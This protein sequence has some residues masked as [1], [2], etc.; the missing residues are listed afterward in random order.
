[1][2]DKLL[3]LGAAYV[4]FARDRP[5]LYRV[6]Y[7][8]ARD[9]ADLPTHMHVDD[10]SAYFQV[11][12]TLIE[13]GADPNDLVGLELATSAAWCAAHGLAEL[14]AFKQFAPLKESL[15]GE[16][17]FLRGVLEHMGIF[18]AVPKT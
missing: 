14:I 15:G 13:G 10:D 12:D 17:A 2:R 5:A 6:M 3:A 16:E 18:S 8:C 11:R 9:K 7:D 1:V 4:R